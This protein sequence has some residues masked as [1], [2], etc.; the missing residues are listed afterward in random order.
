MTN[1]LAQLR[2]IRGKIS[3]LK[4]DYSNPE[5]TLTQ[6]YRN[7]SVIQTLQRELKELLRD[8]LKLVEKPDG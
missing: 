3:N 6:K 4:A 5:V 8:N 2:E 1:K 7:A